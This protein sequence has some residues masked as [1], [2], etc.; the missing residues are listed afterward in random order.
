M[1]TK[2]VLDLYELTDET[3]QGYRGVFV[4]GSLCVGERIA[5]SSQQARALNL[6]HSLFAEGRLARGNRVCVVGGGAA[7]LTAAAYAITREA[8]VT[9]IES[10]DLLWNLRG[11]RTRWLH[12][13]L[14]RWWPDPRWKCTGTNFPVMNWYAGYAS[15]IGELLHQKYLSFEALQGSRSSR[16][17]LKYPGHQIARGVRVHSCGGEWNVTWVPLTDDA[18]EAARCDVFDVVIIATGFGSEA[19]IRDTEAS[20]Y[21]LDDTLERERPTG[22]QMQY[23]ISGTGD[24]GLTDLLRVRVKGFRHHHLRDCLLDMEPFAAEI[25]HRIKEVEE[26]ARLGTDL[27]VTEGYKRIAWDRA[28]WRLLDSRRATTSVV[29]TNREG[30]GALVSPA[31]RVSKFLAAQLL[32]RDPR[33]EY[34]AGPA[35]WEPRDTAAIDADQPRPHPEKFDVRF[36]KGESS[37]EF[38][39]IVV[40]HGPQKQTHAMWGR[41]AVA[42]S[43]VTLTQ[44]GFE[45]RVIESAKE[46]WRRLAQL[47][48]T[49]DDPVDQDGMQTNFETRLRSRIQSVLPA[50]G[51]RTV[52]GMLSRLVSCVCPEEEETPTANLLD[53]EHPLVTDDVASLL[54]QV[55]QLIGNRPVARDDSM[56]EEDRGWRLGAELNRNEAIQVIWA[57]D[58]YLA[59][60][61]DRRPQ[62]TELLERNWV[63]PRTPWSSRAPLLQHTC[64]ARHWA[65]YRL[66]YVRDEKPMALPK[67]PS[68]RRLEQALHERLQTIGIEDAAGDSGH[69][70]TIV[71][72]C[73][74]RQRI[75][76]VAKGVPR[77]WRLARELAANYLYIQSFN[78]WHPLEVPASASSVLHTL[79]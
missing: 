67:R 38:D 41:E 18:R 78:V 42:A 9:V 1:K 35:R 45:R 49:T 72:S 65:P 62:Q 37:G 10:N 26:R 39:A 11:C 66:K 68:R 21:W 59:D 74:P 46:K 55:A 16:K 75:A 56:A 40:R 29:L 57:A 24:G 12:P 27:D 6:V 22:R 23:L 54:T 20:L 34:R 52:I 60:L 5:V 70:L 71:D 77:V 64:V 48:Q 51:G 14:F 4:I 79:E 15:D 2:D 43:W 44:M 25:D 17:R 69:L 73:V 50:I 63:L 53:I 33:T 58:R 61:W 36:A 19:R 7:G 13:N 47:E 30:G 3:N 8:V 76:V 31:W 32:M 28:L